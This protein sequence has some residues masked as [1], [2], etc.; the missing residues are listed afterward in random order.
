MKVILRFAIIIA[1][2][3]GIG[4]GVW[5]IWFRKSDEENVYNAIWDY[6]EYI[7]EV[8]IIGTVGSITDIADEAVKNQTNSGVFA[9]IKSLLFGDGS[10]TAGFFGEDGVYESQR[11]MI[12]YFSKYAQFAKNVGGLS[13]SVTSSISKAR[14]ATDTVTDSVKKL[15]DW[16]NQ[17]NASTAGS[18]DSGGVI[19]LKQ[20]YF[21][22]YTASQELIKAQYEVSINVKD[23]VLQ[24]AMGGDL[25]S[26]AR[27]VLID[28]VTHANAYVIEQMFDI[29]KEHI[30]PD[31][32]TMNIFMA[33]SNQIY[34]KAITLT[35]SE[36]TA[37]EA[38]EFTNAYNHLVEVDNGTDREVINNIFKTDSKH[39]LAGYPVNNGSI[40]ST[41]ATQLETYGITVNEYPYV[42]TV[43]AFLGY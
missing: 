18:A 36:L 22:L 27:A 28:C 31:V 9:E 37:T 2:V 12:E 3:V 10:S 25:D 42:K 38:V 43:L 30:E 23:Y 14:T 11:Y 7:D 16:Q 29:T 21:T 4:F 26:D 6:E 39:T 20:H 35:R 32:A 13:K 5:A 15:L 34:K 41:Y 19:E 1:V 8:D 33:D 24:Y 17:L 40:D